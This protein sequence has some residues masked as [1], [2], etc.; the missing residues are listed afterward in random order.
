[1]KLF[2]RGSVAL[3]ELAL[4]G[5]LV[6]TLPFF[7]PKDVRFSVSFDEKYPRSNS[8][9]EAGMIRLPSGT[10]WLAEWPRECK[11]EIVF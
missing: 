2:L 3:D 9:G 10:T 4:E 8:P 1:M 5:R 7:P 11:S 6:N